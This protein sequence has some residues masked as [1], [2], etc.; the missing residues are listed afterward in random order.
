MSKL[1]PCLWRS[2]SPP[3]P[4]VQ[5]KT[6]SRDGGWDSNKNNPAESC[7]GIQLLSFHSL[8]YGIGSDDLVPS[9]YGSLDSVPALLEHI[10]VLY[11]IWR[12]NLPIATLKKH[13]SKGGGV[14]P[15]VLQ[16]RWIEYYVGW[17]TGMRLKVLN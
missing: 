17:P 6:Y 9:G 11:V 15:N 4:P 10:K 12:S 7:D 14:N 13:H 16:A 3:P 1:K 5:G 2:S 8:G